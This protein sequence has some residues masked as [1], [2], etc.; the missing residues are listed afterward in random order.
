MAI[1]KIE[2]NQS[3]MFFKAWIKLNPLETMVLG[4][5]FYIPIAS[6]I[7]MVSERSNY[8]INFFSYH[9]TD[10]CYDN[11]ILTGSTNAPIEYKDACWLVVITFLT[12]GYGDFYPLTHVGRTMS[13][14][15]VLFG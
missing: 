7:I 15:T 2:N 3:L 5:V 9:Q 4:C 12:V 10:V 11:S 8:Y 6:Y 14:I 13:I 1:S